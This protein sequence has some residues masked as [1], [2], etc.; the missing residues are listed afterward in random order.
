MAAIDKILSRRIKHT[1]N[2]ILM[3]QLRQV[4]LGQAPLRAN[5]EVRVMRRNMILATA[6]MALLSAPAF[7]QSSGMQNAGGPTRSQ[8]AQI[9]DTAQYVASTGTTK[10]TT[11]T[12]S[13]KR[14]MNTT[15]GNCYDARNPACQNYRPPQ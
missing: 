13:R 10:K 12:K 1:R 14:M 3:V 15:S 11:S 4:R 8:I 2:R 6:V 9:L 7:A 5:R